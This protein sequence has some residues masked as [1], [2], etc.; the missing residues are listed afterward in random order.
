MGCSEK[1]DDYL[2][3]DNH[4]PSLILPERSEKA[5]EGSK[6]ETILSNLDLRNRENYMLSEILSGNIPDFL[7]TF[8]PVTLNIQHKNLKNTITFF[9]LSDYMALG[10]NNDYFIIPMTP[11]LAQKI[12]NA[13]GLT[14]L[15]KK[16]VDLVWESSSL[17]LDPIPIPPS[18]EMVTI[19]VFGM[20]NQLIYEMRSI[21]LENHK[22][23]VLVAGHKKDVIISNRIKN[24]PGK[25]I[26]YGW[27]Q[28]NGNPI[29]P[30]YSGHAIWYADYSHGI[31][32][33][34]N[35]CIINNDTLTITDILHHDEYYYFFS[36]DI[37]P[38]EI[39]KYSID[40]TNYP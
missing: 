4:I 33:A 38:M 21:N 34:Y 31:R 24:D 39:T 32:L 12:A 19:P 23:G 40:D 25:V 9:V 7:R 29:Q 26:I 5:P 8:V 22:L 2:S 15:T 14:F 17:K 35:K 36:D 16:M 6:L 20:H 10:S 1:K 18:N 27:H 13:L 11:I 37:E 30:I 3:I 28:L